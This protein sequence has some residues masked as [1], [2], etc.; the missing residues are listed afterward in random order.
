MEKRT[1]RKLSQTKIKLRIPY[2]VAKKWGFDG[3]NLQIFRGNR[4]N[5]SKLL[6]EAIHEGM[7]KQK[8]VIDQSL[9]GG[10]DAEIIEK[11]IWVPETKKNEIIEKS[12]NCTI[13]G[14]L[15]AVLDSYFSG[16]QENE[17]ISKKVAILER[18]LREL[19]EELWFLSVENDL[20]M[21]SRFDPKKFFD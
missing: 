16:H 19:Q 7:Q 8:L 5:P 15:L 3:T 14:Y 11:T 21:K 17:E 4:I 12:I 9:Y 2:E 10:T 18:K 20:N 6:R 13:N 1:N